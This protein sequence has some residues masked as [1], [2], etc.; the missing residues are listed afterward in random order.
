[1]HSPRPL[2]ASVASDW[3]SGGRADLSSQVG[4]NDPCPCGSGRKFKRCCL[5]RAPTSVPSGSP[6]RAAIVGLSG[7]GSSRFR[8]QAGSYGGFQGCLPSIACLKR[9]ATGDWAYHFVLVVPDDVREDEESAS[10]QAG[11]HLFAVFQGGSSPET[12]AN[13]LREIGYVSVSGFRVVA[14]DASAERGFVPGE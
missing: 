9:E 11:E 8:F 3:R 14:D 4:R 7:E 13:G 10:L 6:R 1:M 12:V 5:D 2:D